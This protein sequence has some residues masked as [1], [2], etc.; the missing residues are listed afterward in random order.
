MGSGGR[1]L[2]GK[3]FNLSQVSSQHLGMETN[4]AAGVYPVFGKVSN[5]RPDEGSRWRS[6]REQSL[7]GL[8]AGVVRTVRTPVRI[9]RMNKLAINFG[10]TAAAH[11]SCF[12]P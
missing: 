11:I 4:P 2:K 10:V 7:A 1:V 5:G 8:R 12:V 3:S 6:S 9:E